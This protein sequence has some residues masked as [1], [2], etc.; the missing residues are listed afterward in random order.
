VAAPLRPMGGGL[1]GGRGPG[2]TIL[3]QIRRLGAS[4]D[5][6][7]T[8]FTMDEPRSRA[9]TEAF[10]RLFEEGKIY[11]STRLVH[12]SYALKTAI[13]TIEVDDV[14]ITPQTNKRK[15]GGS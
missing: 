13:S 9:V 11:R 2:A 5:H 6:S 7:R 14:E 15:V 4:V 12:W 8:V 3:S 10:V 1:T